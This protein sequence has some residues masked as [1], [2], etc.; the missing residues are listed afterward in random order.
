MN[1][2]SRRSLLKSGG[3]LAGALATGFSGVF[4]YAN[5]FAQSD[6]DSIETI[7]NLATTAE[8]LAC[9]HYYTALTDSTIPLTPNERR[10]MMAALDTEFQHLKFLQT[11][12][13][14]PLTTQ[15]FSPLNV[16]VDRENFSE[17]TEQAETAFVGAYLAATRR[18]AELEQPLLAATVAQIAATEEVHLALIRQLGERLPNHVAFAQL[19]GLNTSDTVPVL[20]P[21]IEGGTGFDGPRPY[22]GDVAITDLV[23]NDGVRLGDT[24]L[25]VGSDGGS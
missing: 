16:Y 23:A 20:Q 21:F 25:D 5:V 8:M 10:F 6:G 15:F 2:L 22:P 4:G 18:L 11:N 19:T 3:V 24:F 13:G 12:N 14:Q 9:T 17:I 7:L 1:Q